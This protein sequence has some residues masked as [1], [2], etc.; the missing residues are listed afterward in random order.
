MAPAS[1]FL[2]LTFAVSERQEETSHAQVDKA[3]ARA[4]EDMRHL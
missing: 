4:A 1:R 2:Q 3:A